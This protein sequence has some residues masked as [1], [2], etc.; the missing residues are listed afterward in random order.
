VKTTTLLAAGV[1]LLLA[2]PGAAQAAPPAVIT[3]SATN[4]QGTS[5][6]LTGQ[7]TTGGLDSSY[8][9]EYVDA[10]QFAADQ[11]N[12]FAH[13]Q[14]TLAAPLDAGSAKRTAAV[15]VTGLT[16]STT[17]HYRLRAENAAG[18]V[19]GSEPTFTTF[20]GFGFQPGSGGFD[21]RI[22]GEGTASRVT[23]AGSH[24]YSIVTTVNFSL[25]GEVDGN[26]GIP[27]TDG[28]ARDIQLELPP[29]LIE[30]P[31]AVSKCSQDD[32]H[33]P[34]N[35]PFE[36]SRSGER[37]PGLSQ[38]GTVEVRSSADGGS[39]RTFGVFN[40]TPPPGFP[41][42]IGFSPYGVPIAFTPRIRDLGGEY[43]ITLDLRNLSQQVDIYGLT[44]TI[45]GT[46]WALS[47]NGQRGEC[48]NEAEPTF[49]FAKCPVEQGTRDH[50]PFAYLT[51]PAAC[52]GP[53]DFGI[54][55]SSWQQA[56]IARATV[57]SRGDSGAPSG[58]TGCEALRFEPVVT[59]Q[60]TNPRASSP[61]GFDF[62]LTPKEEALT[63]PKRN[64]PSQARRAVVRLPDGL[65]V[66]PSLAAGLGSCSP[67]GYAT[68]TATSPLGAGCPENSKIGS[69]TVQSQLFE[70]TVK[71]AIYLADPD[72]PATKTPGAE[73]PFDSL[74]A[75]Y[76]VAKLPDRGVVVKVAGKLVPDPGSGRLTAT[77]DNLPQL[78]YANL[79]MHFREGQ[80]A[81]LV[82]PSACGIFTTE[83]A[84]TP[85]NDPGAVSR[86]APQF[87]IAKGI[88]AGEACPSSATPPFSPGA[89]SGTL[90]GNA[91]SYSPFYLRLTRAD[92]EQELTSYSTILPPGLTGKIAGIP[93]C[94]DAA[95]AAA[96]RKT[97]REEERHPSCPA[98]S[99]IGHTVSG[100]G[101]SAVL[102]YAPG[103]LY[104]AG[105]YHGSTFSVVAVNSATVGPF[106]LGVIVVRSAIRVDRRTAQV[107][108]D[109]SGSDP[110]PHI[111]AGI[112]IHLRD[113]R[114]YIDRPNGTLNPTSCAPFAVT[115]R[116]TG[117]GSSFADF[118]DDSVATTSNRFQ[119]TNCSALGFAP[120]FSLHL[121]GG[122]KRG[123]FPSLRADVRPRPGNANIA[124]AA[125]TLPPSL[126]LAQDHID[127]VCTRRQFEA[128]NCPR[129]S[130]YGQAAAITPLL[131][132]P[133]HGPVYLRA[134]DNPLPDLVVALR[135]AGIAIDL[136]GRID[137]FRSGIRA[138]FDVVPDA[139]VTRFSLTL[140]GGKRGILV[141][142]D[143]VCTSRQRA[144]ARF[145][146]H[147]NLGQVTHPRMQ[148]RCSKGGTR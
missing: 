147:T 138:T 21:V 123:D 26:P 4:L 71:G 74:L 139:P 65:T 75:L 127:G 131:A 115:S 92:S 39:S 44:L 60:V 34:R 120:R 11:P 35:S 12:G 14:A 142:A 16:P 121:K 86:S 119:V 9:F 30:N 145:V 146:G 55:A 53:I 112:P 76:L 98:A 125:V 107:S 109:S 36:A 15:F 89:A 80:R 128:D 94:P 85:W 69:F 122:T 113:V 48:L 111:L 96:K 143:N 101:A 114:V 141:N 61:S 110:I 135:G 43:G 140:K 6:V 67:D 136:I 7:V 82:T 33:T 133:L 40:L 70:E 50:D 49:P 66:N 106:D 29:G 59:G 2:F 81:P 3:T 57:P 99:E 79:K 63:N 116:L 95:I 144:L 20:P 132:S 124:A 97:G 23:Q 18:V 117:S 78:P 64:V 47:H 100:Y 42:Q 102:A 5:A 130:V 87:Q 62:S 90:N 28:D 118:R 77:F 54:E 38:I 91:G 58:L 51:L 72:D 88:G 137:S 10:G 134:S 17:Y 83:V 84:L 1:T 24:P 45:W 73:N 13:A 108:I 31:S 22:Y 126:F 37:C 52:G 56:A 104:L 32:F 103:K 19:V 41:S 27:V 68:E 25:A 46:P 8:H 129:D 105:P 148:A 93:Y